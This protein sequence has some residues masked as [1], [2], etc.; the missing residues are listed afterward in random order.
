MSVDDLG[1]AALGPRFPIPG[2]DSTQ[3]LMGGFPDPG[4]LPCKLN[5][6][7]FW[8]ACLHAEEGFAVAQFER[9]E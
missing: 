4:D 8:P 5:Y 6:T 7:D 9:F 3:G 1:D 2:S